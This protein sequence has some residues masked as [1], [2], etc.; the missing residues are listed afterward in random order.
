[1]RSENRWNYPTVQEERYGKDRK[2]S[3]ET[4]TTARLSLAAAIVAVAVLAAGLAHSKQVFQFRAHNCLIKLEILPEEVWQARFGANPDVPRTHEDIVALAQ[5]LYPSMETR[6]QEAEVSAEGE[7]QWE[8]HEYELG[9]LF[10]ALQNPAVSDATREQVAYIILNAVPNLQWVDPP[11]Q[12]KKKHFKIHY[13]NYPSSN[14]LKI[15]NSKLADVKDLAVKLEAYWL[16]Y[17]Q[18]FKEP[19]SINHMLDVYLFPLPDKKTVGQTNSDWNYIFLDNVA[20]ADSCMRKT[21][22]AHELFHRVQYSY[23]YVSGSMNGMDWLTEGTAVYIQKYA[24]Q[25]VRD[26]M[27]KMNLGVDT[28]NTD[29]LNRDYDASHFWV[30]LAERAKS[31]LPIRDVWQTFSTNGHLPASAISTVTGKYLSM[32][33][34]LQNSTKPSPKRKPRARNP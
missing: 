1:L 22:S 32:R 5:K 15:N 16:I 8:C 10:G 30:Y 28:P 34:F 6:E 20:M 3:G 29:L 18:Q 26:Y 13:T 27:A 11:Y 14:P 23:G 19:K 9:V 7:T 12:S 17:S 33:S 21:R 4:K 25:A 31:Y 24:N 2:A